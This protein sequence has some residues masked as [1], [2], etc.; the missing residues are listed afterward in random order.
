MELP[1][2]GLQTATLILAA[3][4]SAV[5]LLTV[6]LGLFSLV[7]GRDHWP[8]PMRRLRR[9]T[10]ASEEDF[11]VHGTY[12]M[13]NGGAMLLIL[14]GVTMNALSIGSRVGEPANTLRFVILLIAIATSLACVVGAYTLGLRIHYV[15]SRTTTGDR[16][17][18]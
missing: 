12:M 5:G 13:L 11:R 2:Q 9:R 17:G 3:V 14:L 10:P 8:V 1:D 4:V 7:T 16:A 15:S 6:L 18:L